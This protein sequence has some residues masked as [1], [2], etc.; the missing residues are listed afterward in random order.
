MG[1]HEVIGGIVSPV[2]DAYGKKGLVAQTHRLEMVRL[3]LKSSDW[4]RLSDWECRQ[5]EWS[6]T[7]NTLQFHQNYLNSVIRDIDN[8][9]ESNFPSWI[10]QNIRNISEPVQVKLL[11][12]ADLLESFATPD[13]WDPDDVSRL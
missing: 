8:F 9:N 7:R 13:L 6:R 5:S 12:G 1:T 4:I 10:P 11:C 2:H 3:A